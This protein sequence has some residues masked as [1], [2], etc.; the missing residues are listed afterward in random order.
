PF[1]IYR[2]DWRLIGS[3][4]VNHTYRAALQ[5]MEAGR[6]RVDPLISQVISLA[7]APAFFANGRNP[8]IMKVQIA[9]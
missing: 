5:W 3:M 4:A 6:F 2:M 9:F 7:E 8:D 1:D